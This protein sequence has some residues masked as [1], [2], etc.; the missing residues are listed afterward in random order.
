[1]R[2]YFALILFFLSIISNAQI[3]SGKVIYKI[4]ENPVAIQGLLEN[5]NLLPEGKQMLT[6]RFA[7]ERASVGYIKFELLFNKD[8]SL[9]QSTNSQMKHD[10]GLDLN[11][12]INRAGARGLF[13]TNLPENL[14]LHQL[15]YLDRDWLVK[16]KL[17][18]REWKVTN[19][20]KQIQGYT[21]FKAITKIK[22]KDNSFKE[23]EAWFTPDIPFQFGPMN[24]AG[25][26]GIILEME[27]RYYIFY[28]DK[29]EFSGKVNQIKR[30]NKGELYTSEDYII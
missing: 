25:L 26:P 19:E 30:P 9:F 14:L 12:V 5:P 13:Y 20:T 8:E 24:F 17:D 6:E 21:C 23:L 10:A 15:H 27:Y 2:N 3:Q 11:K 7:S 4:K 29:L 16:D 28:A 22:M 18:E 1:M